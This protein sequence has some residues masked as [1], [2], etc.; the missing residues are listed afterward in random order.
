M[1][2]ESSREGR[3]ISFKK[4]KARHDHNVRVV[5][6]LQTQMNSDRKNVFKATS[7]FLGDVQ[8]HGSWIVTP[9][10]SSTFLPYA[11]SSPLPD[12][13]RRNI[14]DSKDTSLPSPFSFPVA[15]NTLNVPVVGHN[16]H[17]SLCPAAPSSGLGGRIPPSHTPLA[18]A[19]PAWPDLGHTSPG[20]EG[21]GAFLRLSGE[22]S[23]RNI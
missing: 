12:S 1:P 8:A 18:L 14:N 16:P 6:K 11:L 13:S 10:F 23:R 19:Q 5:L 15:I 7:P 3:E 17:A 4:P 2:G 21:S 9:A 20:R 22:C